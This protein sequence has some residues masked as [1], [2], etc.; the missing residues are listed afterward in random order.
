MLILF[1]IL[2]AL[3]TLFYLTLF[4]YFIRGWKKLKPFIDTQYKVATRFSIIIPAR[5]EEK[6]I[7]GCISGI[8][9]QDYPALAFEIIVVDDCSEDNTA[10]IVTDLAAQFPLSNIKLIQLG[11]RKDLPSNSFK[12]FA[13]SQ[14]ISESQNP[15]IITTDADCA[16]PKN[17]LAAFASFIEKY[18]PVMV[19]GPVELTSPPT[20]RFGGTGSL[21]LERGDAPYG[22]RH[23]PL[24][25]HYFFPG[26]QALEFSGLIAIGG[27]CMRQGSPNLCNGANFAYR[28]D[29]FY[30]VDG[31]KGIDDIASGDDE[32]LMHKIAA[33]YKD[34]VM[35]LKSKEAIVTTAPQ[36]NFRAFIQ[37]RKRWVSK[38]RK[39]SKKGITLILSSAYVFNL[40]L[41]L[42]LLLSFY[43]ICFLLLFGFSMVVKL[44]VE[45]IF[46]GSAAD[47]MGQKPLMKKFLP[48]SLVYI[49]YVLFIGIYGNFGQYNWKGRNVK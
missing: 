22:N 33:K 27:A 4:I 25:T 16:H 41:V 12:K 48:A 19:S 43:S 5:N 11:D 2:T 44:C 42:N 26:A 17:W 3:F 30:E 9:N 49:L 36:P 45:Y 13:L 14:G 15:W 28:K 35:F 10:K 8:I 21:L 37:Q 31:Y 7:A 29:V 1:S 38:S 20:S 34:R 18:S 40:L 46:L 6:N 23:S 24:A 39:Y 47:F 32:L